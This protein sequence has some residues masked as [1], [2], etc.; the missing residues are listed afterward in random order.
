MSILR[1]VP[2][3]GGIKQGQ[4]VK[5]R[6]ICDK[7]VNISKTIGDRPKLLLM[8][9]MKSYML[10]RL[11][12]RSMTLDEL[13]LLRDRVIRGMCET[14]T[15]KL[16]NVNPYCQGRRCNPLKLLFKIM[17][18]ALICGRF[19]GASFLGAYMHCCHVLTLALARLSCFI[20]WIVI[21]YSFP[22]ELQEAPHWP[23]PSCRYAQPVLA[24]WYEVR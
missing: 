14:T 12:P 19:L 18:L 3:P 5:T 11:T 23:R 9:Y 22:H 16:M 13:E 7:C 10:F 17:F 2:L 20:C 4:G 8:T 21:L 15:A 6:C 24:R 1:S